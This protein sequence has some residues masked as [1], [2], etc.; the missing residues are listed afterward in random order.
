[1]R[2]IYFLLI[3]IIGIFSVCTNTKNV[4]AKKMFLESRVNAGYLKSNIDYSKKMKLK[5]PK[6]ILKS[7]Q[8][9][10]DNIIIYDENGYIVDEIHSDG[11]LVQYQ[12]NKSKC[13]VSD[14]EG[15]IETYSFN[16]NQKPSL[17]INNEK[18]TCLKDNIGYM[19][20]SASSVTQNNYIVKNL[21]MNKIIDDSKFV[22]NTNTSWKQSSIQKFLESK[23]SVLKN[24]IKVYAKK[25]NG[26]I[27]NT[28]R[29]ITPSQ[30]IYINARD[31]KI[32]PQVILA[33]IQKESSLI[34]TTKAKAKINS[35]SFYF[36]MGCGATDSGDLNS[37]TG[38][39]RQIQNG[40]KLLF[41][42]YQS[43][44]GGDIIKVN[45][46]KKI[47]IN[48]ITYPAKIKASNSASAALY[49]YTPHVFDTSNGS[50]STIDGGNYLFCKIY[51]GWGWKR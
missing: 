26:N 45:Y 42:L 1:M 9:E 43:S 24:K 36:A 49:H 21:K 6:R 35:R 18:L 5:I 16:N 4:F 39:D 33:T 14:S 25:K 19:Q 30:V 34:T 51:S 7:A 12:Y 11:Y 29:T 3:C 13:I 37:Y 47:T 50:K 10:S 22:Y 32:N 20:L 31:Y 41:R 48:N 40:A 8:E 38:F 27:Y 23:N 2:K 44:S 15:N 17:V 46:G 28:G